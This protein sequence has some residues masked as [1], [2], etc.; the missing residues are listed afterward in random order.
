MLKSYQGDEQTHVMKTLLTLHERCQIWDSRGALRWIVGS[1]T[2]IRK[3]L[4]V[5]DRQYTSCSEESQARGPQ[6]L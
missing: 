4:S 3:V 1:K 2:F 5:I 6:T